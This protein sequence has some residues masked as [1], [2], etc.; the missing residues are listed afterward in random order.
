[1]STDPRTILVLVDAEQIDPA[2]TAEMHA[3]A[4]AG[5]VAFD[6]LVANPVRAEVHLLHP[7]RHRDAERR[8]HSLNAE[9]ALLQG[10]LGCPVRG[11]VSIRHDLF[12]AAEEHLLLHHAD[13]ILLATAEHH[14]AHAVHH[15]LPQRLAHLGLPV[16]RVPLPV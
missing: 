4:A 8:D 16:H 1:M 15:D 12:E 7:D 5:E 9:I 13:E 14:L 11:S 2:T 6:V 10:T 3:R